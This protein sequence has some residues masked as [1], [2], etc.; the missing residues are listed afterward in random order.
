MDPV[1]VVGLI[2]GI[3]SLTKLLDNGLSGLGDFIDRSQRVDETIQ[4]F[5]DDIEA[6]SVAIASV[7]T[8]IRGKAGSTLSLNSSASQEA[9]QSLSISVIACQRLIK[10]LDNCIPNRHS[11][12]GKNSFL[13]RLWLQRRLNQSKNTIRGVQSQIQ[14]HTGIINTAL[15]F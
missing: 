11:F 4:G 6:L 1:S 8:R 15:T 12:A 7:S 14:I 10:S 3:L 13:R 9:A 2:S 5:H